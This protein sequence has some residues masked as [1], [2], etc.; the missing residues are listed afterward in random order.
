MGQRHRPQQRK[1]L[2]RP[3]QRN[4]F[5]ARQRIRRTKWLRRIPA[6]DPGRRTIQRTAPARLRWRWTSATAERPE[7]AHR[8]RRRRRRIRLCRATEEQSALNRTPGTRKKEGLV[9]EALQQKGVE[10]LTVKA[11]FFESYYDGLNRTARICLQQGNSLDA[12]GKGARKGVRKL[13][14]ALNPL[15]LAC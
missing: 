5:P 6:R 11:S 8:S 15:R 3:H 9:E 1:Q 10:I 12:I 14:P 2:P 7:E 13:S 4:Q